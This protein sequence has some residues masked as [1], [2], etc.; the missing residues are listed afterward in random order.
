MQHHARRRSLWGKGGIASTRDRCFGCRSFSHEETAHNRRPRLGIG[1]RAAR[2]VAD[3][4][5]IG[6]IETI[7]PICTAASRQIRQRGRTRQP[8]DTREPVSESSTRASDLPGQALKL[9]RLPRRA[10]MPTPGRPDCPCGVPA[11]THF[12]G[13]FTRLVIAIGVDHNGD[14]SPE[15]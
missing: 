1:N 7:F 9:P 13:C 8:E 12:T 14:G 3:F 15:G 11:G 10:T 2:P 4:R 5:K 6:A